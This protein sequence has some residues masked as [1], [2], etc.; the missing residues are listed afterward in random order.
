MEPAI[1]KYH[2]HNRAI[3]SIKSL[4]IHCDCTGRRHMPTL[5]ITL[6]RTLNLLITVTL[7][8]Y[9]N[10]AWIESLWP[11]LHGLINK[12]QCNWGRREKHSYRNKLQKM[13]YSYFF[14]I[15]FKAIG[16]K[17]LWEEKDWW[18]RFLLHWIL[19]MWHFTHIIF[20]SFIET[21]GFDPH[22]E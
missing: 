6:S 7:V 16:I 2:P 10:L 17:M 20:R 11:K 9:P 13:Y 4:D 19:L 14:F 22:I 12:D 18:T 3:I 15:L 1:S 5:I 21:K 8:K